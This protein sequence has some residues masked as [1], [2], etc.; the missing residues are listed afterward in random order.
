MNTINSW[1]LRYASIQIWQET[2][3]DW[4]K[5]NFHFNLHYINTRIYATQNLS[6]LMVKNESEDIEMDIGET[7]P[8]VFTGINFSIVL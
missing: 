4:E 8:I 3:D 5:T 7:E 1:K 2:V 6:N